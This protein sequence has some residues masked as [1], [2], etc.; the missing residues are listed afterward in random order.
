MKKSA[1]LFKEILETN[2]LIKGRLNIKYSELEK[3]YFALQKDDERLIKK[4]SHHEKMIT[5]NIMKRNAIKSQRKRNSESLQKSFYPT[6]N[7]VSLLYKKQGGAYYIKA[8]FY[9]C[10]RQR[11]VQVGSIS[12]VIEI[13]NTMIKNKI[14]SEMKQVRTTKLTWEQISK[15]PELINAIKLIASLKAQ[16]YILRR[17]FAD[18]LNVIDKIDANDNDFIPVEMEKRQNINEENGEKT[19]GVEWYERWRRDNL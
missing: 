15:R 7:K 5:R 1:P 12:I 8:R 4:Q 11:E 16:E 6:T 18:K 10:G 9:W 19:E 3:L 2:H 13:I 14:L 17:L